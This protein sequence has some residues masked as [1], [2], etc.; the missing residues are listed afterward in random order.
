MLNTVFCESIKLNLEY[1]ETSIYQSKLTLFGK[2]K[3]ES[4]IAVIEQA[5]EHDPL[6]LQDGDKRTVQG[7]R[8]AASIAEWLFMHYFFPGMKDK[9][10]WHKERENYSRD[11]QF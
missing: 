8:M 9:K 1:L 2:N 11:M 3:M 10:R 7:R 6:N 5:D 4:E